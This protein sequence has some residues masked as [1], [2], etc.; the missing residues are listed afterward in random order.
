VSNV[1]DVCFF[2]KGKG[3]NTQWISEDEF[4]TFVGCRHCDA[5][6]EH[7]WYSPWGVGLYV[8]ED[9]DER[10][11]YDLRRKEFVIQEFKGLRSWEL[12]RE[13]LAKELDID[14]RDLDDKMALEIVF[15]NNKGE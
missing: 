15:S 6:H 12:S 5:K 11:K 3:T 1:I 10:A 7:N 9:C 4:Y 14:P 8:C 2:C 13:E